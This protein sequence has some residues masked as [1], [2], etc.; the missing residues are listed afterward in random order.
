MTTMSTMG[1]LR[2]GAPLEAKVTDGGWGVTGYAAAWSL[3]LQGDEIRP[4]AFKA[5]ISDGH[6]IR[7]LY[8]HRQDQVL[9]TTLELREDAK[10]L[11]GSWRISKTALGADVRQLLL[12][13]ALDS[14]SI[15]FMPRDA[16][17]QGKRR[18]LKEVELVEISVVAVPAQPEARIETVKATQPRVSL[19]QAYRERLQVRERLRGMTLQEQIVYIKSLG[20]RRR[21]ATTSYGGR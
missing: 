16:D 8:S 19:V 3:D 10:G 5:T 9:G 17:H 18:V 1:G 2:F 14:L 20:L 4:G 15:G 13:G 21:M 12:D 11:W 6:P 7:F